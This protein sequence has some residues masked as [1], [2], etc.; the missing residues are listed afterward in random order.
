MI[1]TVCSTYFHLEFS[2]VDV[3]L[4]QLERPMSKLLRTRT[5]FGFGI[6]AYMSELFWVCDGGQCFTYAL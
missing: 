2:G 4:L 3:F 5:I 1:L 6:F